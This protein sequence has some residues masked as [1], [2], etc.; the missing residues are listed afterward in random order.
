MEIGELSLTLAR[1][2]SG[3]VFLYLG[4]GLV[5]ALHFLLRGGLARLDPS[6]GAG[7]RP[8]KLLILPGVVA[9]WPF[10]WR[11]LRRPEAAP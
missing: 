1:V 7:S 11:R 4:G 6:A 2:A 8:F 5:F 9:L 3:L 10:L